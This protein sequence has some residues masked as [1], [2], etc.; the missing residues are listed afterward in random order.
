MEDAGTIF[1]G[2]PK[3]SEVEGVGGLFAKAKGAVKKGMGGVGTLGKVGGALGLID[4]LG[5]PAKNMV[6]GLEDMLPSVVDKRMERVLEGQQQ[7]RDFQRMRA[8]RDKRMQVLQR[9]N[10][11]MMAQYAPHLFNQLMAGRTLPRDATVIGGE[12]RADLVQEVATQMANGQFQM[13]QE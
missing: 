12:P 6:Y 5:R 4:L 9:K 3:P 7:A 13:P 8:E 2:P 11:A 10:T 1:E